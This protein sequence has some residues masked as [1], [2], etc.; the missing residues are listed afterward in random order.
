MEKNRKTDTDKLLIAEFRKGKV[1]AF[2]AIYEKYSSRLYGFALM[3]LKNREDARDI[4]QETFLRVWKKRETIAENRTFKSFLFT[5][6]YNI[7]V[8][9]L[10]KRLNDKKYLELLEKNFPFDRDSGEK[11]VD[12][13]LLQS[14][15]QNLMDELPPRR[16]EIYLLSQGK[17]LSQKEIA[18]RLNITVKTVETHLSLARKFLR[19]KLTDGSLPL[20][21]LFYLF[22]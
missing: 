22:Y 5:V 12:F 11:A 7:I 14:Q 20:L 9:H 4:V 1:Q 2:D 10:R 15:I 3:L 6:S 21:L 16:K 8:D 19:E 13:Y 18:R 17:N